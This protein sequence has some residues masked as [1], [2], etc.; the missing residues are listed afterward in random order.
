MAGFK[1][2][3]P[4]PIRGRAEADGDGASVLKRSPAKRRGDA[5]GA[6]R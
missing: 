1:A 5:E 6:G 4:G 3:A 2:P